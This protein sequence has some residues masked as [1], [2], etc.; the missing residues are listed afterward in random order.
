MKIY[1]GLPGSESLLPILDRNQVIINV[2]EIY[3][4]VET[5]DGS[6]YRYYVGTKNNFEIAYITITASDLETI[7]TEFNRHTELNLKLEKTT[8][9]TYDEYTVLFG[10]DFPEDLYKDFPGDRI[11]KNL[12]FTLKG[13]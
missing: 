4:D 11:Y 5:E 12:S 3:E 1:L 7:L 6:S 2:R 8:P 9:D 10:S 13:V